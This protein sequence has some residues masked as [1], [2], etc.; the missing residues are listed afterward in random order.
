MRRGASN[1]YKKCFHLN[2]QNRVIF[3]LTIPTLMDF[4]SGFQVCS[5]LSFP[6]LIFQ[7]KITQEDLWIKTYGRLYQKLCS[8][9]CE[10]PIGIYRTQH[11]LRSENSSVS[12][13]APLH[14]L[15][16]ICLRDLVNSMDLRTVFKS[17]G[18]DLIFLFN[19]TQPDCFHNAYILCC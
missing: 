7:M 2:H 12:L 3:W 14:F 16:C 8:T 10:I 13:H 11:Q 15:S 9:T 19:F 5:I 17:L 6:F 18:I 1:S 4:F